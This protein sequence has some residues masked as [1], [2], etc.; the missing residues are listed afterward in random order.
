MKKKWLGRI[1]LGRTEDGKQ[2]YHWV[3]RFRTRRERDE[4]VAR[5]RV[6]IE[7]EGCECKGC[8]AMG[9]KGV[10]SSTAPTIATQIN[11][12]LAEYEER[13]RGS[14]LD[15]ETSRLARLKADLGERPVDSIERPELKDWLAGRGAWEGSTSV[16]ASHRQ[17]IVSFFRWNVV[18]EG[19]L[20]TSPATGLNKRSKGRSEEPPPTEAEFEALVAACSVHGDYA[21][22]MRAALVFSAYTLFRP[23]ELYEVKET[24]IDF[25]R[26]RISKARRLYRGQ[27]EEPKTGAKVTA[28]TPPARDAILPILPG[29]GGYLF[30]NKSGDRLVGSTFNGYWREVLIAAGLDFDFYHATKHFGCWYMWT[31]LGMS[32][33]AIAAL[34]G[35][36]LDN[37]R[38]IL[39]LLGVYG[40]GEVGA[41]N[42]V[43]KA[44]EGHERPGLRVVEGGRQ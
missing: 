31:Q 44:F 18:E 4:A 24:D 34:A 21:P 11:R 37:I 39:K 41:L 10:A 28:L 38:E 7:T 35:W 25:R 14:S 5:E 15:T 9:R 26:M 27:V 32:E 2:Q 43:D 16:P 23:S 3:G 40:H 17:A 42:E 1:F 30:K 13:N 19:K 20:V 8:K 33:R 22:M 6:R 29:D 12:Y 36:K